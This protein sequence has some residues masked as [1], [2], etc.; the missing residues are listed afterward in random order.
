MIEIVGLVLLGAAA[1]L[2]AAAIGVGGGIVFVPALVV[3]FAFDQHVAQGTSLAVIF[4]T[5]IVSTIGHARSGRVNWAVAA[6][7]AATGIVGALIGARVALVIDADVLRRLFALLLLAVS[8]RMA[9][10]ARALHRR[11]NQRAE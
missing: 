9:F 5:A 1:G 3:L 4:P 7:L 2:L 10:R 6:P 8:V 11:R